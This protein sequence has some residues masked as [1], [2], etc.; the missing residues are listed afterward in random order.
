MS[1]Y[2]Q[3]FKEMSG[4]GSARKGRYFRPLARF[5]EPLAWSG[6]QPSRNFGEATSLRSSLSYS[7]LVCSGPDFLKM[8]DRIWSI[9]DFW[10]FSEENLLLFA[11]KRNLFY[12]KNLTISS[13]K[14]DNFLQK[15]CRFLPENLMIFIENLKIFVEKTDSLYTNVWRFF[16]KIWWVSQEN[17]DDFCRKSWKFLQKNLTIFVEFN[18]FWKKI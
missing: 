18:D 16:W 6:H 13:G 4:A 5:H 2:Y 17:L 9:I 10:R 11:R 1:C 3:N 14:F 15:I 8:I 7:K 12:K